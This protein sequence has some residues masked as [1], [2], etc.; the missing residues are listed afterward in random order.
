M[1]GGEDYFWLMDQTMKQ[2]APASVEVA[3]QF[4]TIMK[5]TK[6]APLNCQQFR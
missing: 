4:H 2:W 1:G 3:M 5:E 6:K